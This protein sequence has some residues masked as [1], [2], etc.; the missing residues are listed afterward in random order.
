MTAAVG[1]RREA[2]IG[3]AA[4][5]VVGG[6]ATPLVPSTR[7]DEITDRLI[8]AIAIGEYLPGTRLPSERD[9]A[10]S[11]QVGRMT[12]RSAIAR[13][14]ER[15]LLE[16]QRGRGGGSF[17]REQWAPTSSASVHRILTGRWDALRDT[18]EAVRRLH[19]TIARAAAENRTDVDVERL[20]ERLDVFRVADSGLQ[21]QKADELLHLAIGDAANN[22]TLKSVLFEL[23]S[24]VSIAAP[25]HLW[26][27]PEGM[28]EMEL[29][30]L[31]D[32]ENLVEAICAQRPDD[33]AS[34]AR[35]HARIDLELLEAALQRAVGSP[36]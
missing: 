34:I 6:L 17:V 32:H 1:S 3:S 27:A 8:T 30:A 31:V 11:L 21:S 35:E 9:L 26:G 4:A 23:E 36:A 10:A 24:R 22:A 13:L 29:R 19:G 5:A 20:R 18:L 15:G 2:A 14:V 7:A 12:V 16:T 28:R 33:A 25:A